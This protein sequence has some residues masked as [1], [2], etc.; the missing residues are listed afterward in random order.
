MINYEEIDKHNTLRHTLLNDCVDRF[1]HHD[2]G[3]RAYGSC[4]CCPS[5]LKKA[6]QRCRCQPLH[7]AANENPVANRHGANRL[8]SF[9]ARVAFSASAADNELWIIAFARSCK[10]HLE[11]VA[12]AFAWFVAAISSAAYVT[13]DLILLFPIAWQTGNERLIAPFTQARQRGQLHPIT[14]FFWCQ[15]LATPW[16]A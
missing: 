4:V 6:L 14:N 13:F 2:R 1:G 11:N 15:V 8:S 7:E 12:P 5:N 16:V 10:G 3:V 9:A